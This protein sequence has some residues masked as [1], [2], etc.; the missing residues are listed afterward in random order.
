ML[1]KAYGE[2]DPVLSETIPVPRARRSHHLPAPGGRD[3]QVAKL[4]RF[5][6]SVA[7]GDMDLIEKFD[8]V[9]KRDPVDLFDK[10][11]YDFEPELVLIASG[12]DHDQDHVARFETGVAAL[13]PIGPVFGKWL[14][15]HVPAHESPRSGHALS[16][17]RGKGIGVESAEAF[18][19]L[20]ALL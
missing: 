1:L 2:P 16:W 13:R 12:A 20:R 18:K 3:E 17:L 10:Q 7:Y 4:L 14:V 5:D 19:V 11:F 15:P 8:T 9:P 6:C